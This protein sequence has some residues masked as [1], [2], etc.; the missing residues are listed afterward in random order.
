MDVERDR[1]RRLRDRL[2]DGILKQLSDV[3]LNGHPEERLPGNL[4]LSFARVEG[5]LLLLGLKEIALSSGAACSS[6]TMEPSHVLRALGVKD[7]LAHSSL[8]FG[9]GRFNTEVEVDYVVGRVVQEVTRLREISPR[10]ETAEA[11]R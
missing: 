6:A 9:L 5:E 3:Y 2:R 7:D 1:V 8:R 11:M 4:H 10:Y